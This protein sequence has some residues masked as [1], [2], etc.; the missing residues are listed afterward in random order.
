MAEVSLETYLVVLKALAELQRLRIVCLLAHQP[1]CVCQIIAVL[2]LAPSTVSKHLSILQQAQCVKSEKKG[3]WVYYH[4]VNA[5]EAP[6][7]R[8]ALLETL[9]HTVQGDACLAS[10][11]QKLREVLAI[12]PEVLCKRP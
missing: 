11:T 7:W 10:D 1:L 8:V 12:D 6:P 5:E 2:H 4:L 3:K 9:K